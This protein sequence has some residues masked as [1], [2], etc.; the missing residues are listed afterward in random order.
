M[1]KVS[2][3]MLRDIIV[4]CTKREKS[5]RYTIQ[6]LVDHEFFAEGDVKVE[7]LQEPTSETESIMFRLVVPGKDNQKNGQESVEFSY[8]L[9]TD[10]PENV[11]DEMV[12]SGI[13]REEDKKNAVRSVREITDP[14]KLK[15]QQM[16]SGGG[17]IKAPLRESSDD[18]E[19]HS[20][21]HTNDSILLIEAVNQKVNY[22]HY[23]CMYCT[24]EITTI[25]YCR[26]YYYTVL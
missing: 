4:G 22:Y 9:R 2:D 24:V 3:P 18:K 7:I 20:L 11:I 10:V 6:Q 23:Y 21:V 25:L 26:N 17:T 13:L 5:G 12:K 15:L 8:D 1:T 19:K 14:A 16:A